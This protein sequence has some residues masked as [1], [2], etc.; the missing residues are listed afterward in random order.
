MTS[1]V[2]DVA[3][4]PAE[5]G[6]ATVLRTTTE[7]QRGRQARQAVGAE[8]VPGAVFGSLFLGTHGL[9]PDDLSLHPA[10]AAVGVPEPVAEPVA[11]RARQ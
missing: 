9:F 8:L 7:A 11:E 3:S 1:T 5:Q 4:L 10:R 2:A 6:S